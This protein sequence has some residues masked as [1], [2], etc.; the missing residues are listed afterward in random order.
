MHHDWL[1]TAYRL[2]IVWLLL[3]GSASW[4][5][6]WRTGFTG[7]DGVACC[8][9]DDCFRVEARILDTHAD[10]THMLVEVNGRRLLVQ[11][12]AVSISQDTSDWY[13]HRENVEDFLSTADIPEEK[14]CTGGAITEE[15][16][17]C[18]FIAVGL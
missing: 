3:A 10:D 13:C 1:T 14:N 11:Q 16:Y 5:H 4:A 9:E 18:I 7:R 6:D 12:V 15:C 2:L 17:Q 8:R